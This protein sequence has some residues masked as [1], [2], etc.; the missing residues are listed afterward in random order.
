MLL[1]TANCKS[2]KVEKWDFIKLSLILKYR[3]IVKRTF[4]I[5]HKV[6]AAKISPVLKNKS[7]FE[8]FF[9]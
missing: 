8:V 2:R 5:K 9:F 3:L 6:K 7:I 4:S 1:V